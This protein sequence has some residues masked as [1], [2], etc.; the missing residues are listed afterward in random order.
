MRRAERAGANIHIANIGGG[1]ALSSPILV[2][3]AE[4]DASNGD[5]FDLANPVLGAYQYALTYDPSLANWYLGA[6]G[7]YPGTAEYPALV[8]GALLAFAAD[9]P[10]LHQRLRE[11]LATESSGK[12]NI[13]P[14]AWTGPSPGLRPWLEFTGAH[15]E[16]DAEASYD[17][18]V[19]GLRA[20]LDMTGGTSSTRSSLGGFLGFGQA[21]Q[22]F[23]GSASEAESDRLQAGVYGGVRKHALYGQ[24]LVKYEHH[25]AELESLSTAYVRA[26]YTVDLLGLSLVDAR[27][28]GAGSL[29]SLG[30]FAGV[31]RGRQE[32]DDSSS[33]ADIDS[34]S[35]GLYGAYRSGPLQARGILK[36]EHQ[37]L[38][39]SSDAADDGL[40]LDLL[41]LSLEAAY[42][43][44]RG[45]TYLEPRTR[46]SYAHA[47]AGSFED[48]SGTAIDLDNADSLS[49][50]LAARLGWSSLYF[51]LSL[52]HEFLGDT[53]AKVS[54]L[55]FSDDLPGTTARLASGLDWSLADGRLNISLD[56]G[57]ARS[58]DAEEISAI[59]AL[60]FNG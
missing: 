10:A 16:V 45:I 58:S 38:A 56:A 19:T 17:L 22:E 1:S 49:G 18:G 54:G 41:G 20:G 6:L 34:L 57:Y 46:L 36:Y 43:L 40:G 44:Q 42:R 8:S 32:F 9:L 51:D 39:Y 11:S 60:R 14:A 7:I 3:D 50:E 24:A 23:A 59:V 35:A 33:E 53:S 13:E 26:P 47:W 5:A 48:S 37:A 4:S 52:R 15:H 25:A 31:G 29:Y 27:A 30:A 28:W 55:T 2:V 21:R 12:P